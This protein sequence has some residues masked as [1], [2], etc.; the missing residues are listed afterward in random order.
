MLS[1]IA[2][3]IMVAWNTVGWQE[4]PPWNGE[5]D[6]I[7]A[8]LTSDGYG[9]LRNYSFTRGKDKESGNNLAATLELELNNADHKYTP[10]YTTSPLNGLLLPMKQIKIT[11]TFLEVE[12]P[13]FYG[14][15]TKYQIKPGPGDKYAYLY[16]TDGMD[17]LARALVGQDYN[18]RTDTSDDEAV[19]KIL[20]ASGWNPA[21][22]TLDTTS[23][24][25]FNYPETY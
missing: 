16:C 10:T 21:R 15:I 6:D 7:T 13:L 8:D 5:Y 12:Y 2:Y 25:K 19:G 14:F 11:V 17:M 18:T 1:A 23:G 4:T 9:Y 20:D 3:S 24:V 22:R